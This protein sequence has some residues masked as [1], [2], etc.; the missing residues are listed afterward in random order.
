ML[1]NV[2]LTREAL[3]EV[4]EYFSQFDE[5][6]FDVET[7]GEHRAFFLKNQVTWISLATHGRAVVIPMGHPNGNTLIKKATRKKNKITNKFDPVPAVF[8]EPPEQLRPSEVF[9]ALKPLFYSD[10]TKVGHSLIF[11]VLSVMKY[12][13]NE[14]MPGPFSDTKICQ[15]LLNENLKQVGL[16]DLIERY[17]SVKYDHE[18]IGRCVEAHPFKIVAR[19]SYMDAKYTWILWNRLRPLLDQADLTRPI[20]LEMSVNDLEEGVFKVL[21]NMAVPGAPVDQNR[22]NELNVELSDTLIDLEAKVYRAAGKKFNINSAPQKSEVL[23][24]PKKDG[25]QGLRAKVL[26]DG[27]EKKKAKGLELE[28]SDYST[29]ADTLEIYEGNAVVDAL[30]EYAEVN[31][32]LGT[33]IQGYLGDPTNP[34]KPCRIFNGRIHA[35]LVQYGTVTG[36]F[37]CR[38]PN[39][40]NIPRPDT[41]LGKK[42]RSLFQAP[43]GFKLVVADYSQIEMVLLAHFAGPGPLYNGLHNGLDPHSAT[44]AALAGIDPVE[45]MEMVKNEDPEA[46]RLR[47]VAKGV[48]FAVVYGAGP[49]KVASMAS[50]SLKEAKRFLEIHERQFPEI[51]RFKDK[52]IQTCRGRKP[53]HIR[54]ISG[55][56]RR[57]PTI[58]SDNWGLRGRAERQAVNSLIQGSAADLIKL[59]MIRLDE[60]LEDD[61]QLILSVHDE[62]VT[63]CPEDK[64]D[65]CAEIVKE[66]MLGEDIAKLINVPLSSDVKTVD[67]WAEAK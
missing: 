65:R 3:D 54:T 32:I 63:L 50:I 26:T 64:A 12:Y 2:I 66:A 52:V 43:P 67:R 39:L 40:Q 4:V 57:L 38:E 36:R 35:D 9:A 56:K 55:R 47:Q 60:A 44:A 61:M 33:Y 53:P 24:A 42:I 18:N 16:K 15:W 58:F 34:K 7:Q 49:D 27:G 25:G 20:G 48:N 22:L 46:K 14:V 11:D 28:W 51:Y 8:S 37:S 23:F 21:M 6:A 41:D 1:S 29:A 13:D 30:L 5:F 45:F 19:Y 10:R 31:K 62:L 59:A 17:Y